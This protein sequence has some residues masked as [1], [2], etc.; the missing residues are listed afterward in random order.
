MC[1]KFQDLIRPI[2]PKV[3]AISDRPSQIAS[4]TTQDFRDPNV[5]TGPGNSQMMLLGSKLANQTAGII[6]LYKHN[7]NKG[8]EPMGWE[9]Q[10][11]EI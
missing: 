6:L 5:F 3:T 9:F 11:T 1:V 2:G 4:I 7:P 8:D 10:V